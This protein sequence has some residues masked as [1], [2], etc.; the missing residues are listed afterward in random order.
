[1]DKVQKASRKYMGEA[2][3]KIVSR[4]QPELKRI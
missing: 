1:M 2:L 4:T 3:V